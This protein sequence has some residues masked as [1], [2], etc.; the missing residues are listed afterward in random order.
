VDCQLASGSRGE[1][2]L[3]GS[4]TGV[5]TGKEQI[6][7]NYTQYVTPTWEGPIILTNDMSASGQ[8]KQDFGLIPRVAKVF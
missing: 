8:F 3:N 4:P 5:K 2:G 1:R 6:R 7:V